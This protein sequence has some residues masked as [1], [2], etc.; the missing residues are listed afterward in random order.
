MSLSAKIQSEIETTINKFIDL[1][2]TDCKVDR[3]TLLN[4]W[5]VTTGESI[6][7]SSE[8]EVASTVSSS[9]EEELLKSS[10]AELMDICKVKGLKVRGSKNSGPETGCCCE[11][12]CF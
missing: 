11:E 9:R 12:I 2:V 7:E 10:K 4:L 5:K 3:S 1:V 6:R 8:S